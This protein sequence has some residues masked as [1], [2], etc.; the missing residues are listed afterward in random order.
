M[1]YNIYW[2]AWH[3][4]A[5]LYIGTTLI[6]IMNDL[7]IYWTLYDL[8]N[9]ILTILSFIMFLQIV[10]EYTSNMKVWSIVFNATF[11]SISFIIVV[12]I[13]IGGGNRR[14]T[15]TCRKSL[16]NFIT[17]C[18]IKYT[19][20]FMGFELTMLVVK[21]TDCTGSCKS[22]YHTLTTTMTLKYEERLEQLICCN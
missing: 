4:K 10:H 19:S 6:F 20:P 14:K 7:P 8:K 18:C 1:R 2:I 12:F 17:Q 15:P 21:G 9:E 5:D 3:A 13:F 22:I 11:N 16:T